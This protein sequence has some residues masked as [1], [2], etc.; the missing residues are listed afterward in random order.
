MHRTTT[1][2]EYQKYIEKDAALERRFQPIMINEPSVED[3]IAILRGLRERYEIF[4]GVHITEAAIHA[5]SD[6]LPIA[7]S[8]KDVCPTRR[9]TSLT[10]LLA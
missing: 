7:T 1:L 10:K 5:A 6:A 2:N 9:S 3:S 8:L 4:H